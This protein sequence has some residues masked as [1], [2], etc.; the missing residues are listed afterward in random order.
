MIYIIRVSCDTRVFD[1]RRIQEHKFEEMIYAN[2]WIDVFR[3]KKK[4][5]AALYIFLVKY[6]HE[7]II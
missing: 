5:H 1:C 6:T 3:I 2:Y 4:L 7:T